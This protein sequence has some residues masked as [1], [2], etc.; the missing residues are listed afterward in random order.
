[1]KRLRLITILALL[2]LLAA[3]VTSTGGGAITPGAK[4]TAPQASTHSRGI[5]LATY[6]AHRWIVQLKAAPLATYRGGVAGLHGTA[7][8]STGQSRLNV[9]SP[10]SR[11][12][13]DHLQATQRAFAERLAHS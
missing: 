11:A 5:D 12:Y 10:R 2:V 8:A 6:P 3:A 13:V 4:P 9:S 1:M 7:S